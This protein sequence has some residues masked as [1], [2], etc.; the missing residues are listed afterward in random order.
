MKNS[1]PFWTE[2][3]DL[4]TAIDS[5]PGIGEL[6]MDECR[7]AF[8]KSSSDIEKVLIPFAELPSLLV[9]LV[10]W[11]ETK[12]SSTDNNYEIAKLIDGALS[13]MKVNQNLNDQFNFAIYLVD[14]GLKHL[15]KKRLREPRYTWLVT[16]ARRELPSLKHFEIPDEQVMKE[17]YIFANQQAWASPDV[18]KLVTNSNFKVW[19]HCWLNQILKVKSEDEVFSAVKLFLATGFIRGTSTLSEMSQQLVD[20]MM[21]PES[22][23]TNLHCARPLT[24]LLVRLLILQIYAE[25]VRRRQD[26]QRR[27]N[28]L[29]RRRS[30][31]EDSG[32]EEDVFNPP[33]AKLQKV[34]DMVAALNLKIDRD[35]DE[36]LKEQIKTQ[37]EYTYETQKEFERMQ[38]MY[39]F[40]EDKPGIPDLDLDDNPLP[41]GE[42]WPTPRIVHKIN[43]EPFRN[44]EEVKSQ[45]A[46]TSMTIFMTLKRIEKQVKVPVLRGSVTFAVYLLGELAMA[47]RSRFYYKF[48]LTYLWPEFVSFEI[49]Y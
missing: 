6:M 49:A 46:V 36:N 8:L 24:W 12:L 2:T 27:K 16:S 32:T 37:Y 23:I 3:S 10:Q 5:I 19:V 42:F 43:H 4:G 11:L 39:I 30:Q 33:P 40:D 7:R 13:T 45:A 22:S 26:V 31:V 15:I 1:K 21:Q 48:L 28:T 29:K 25:Q 41:T 35:I 18:I 47:P 20:L 14:Y 17:A 9:C 38:S 44:F 34:E